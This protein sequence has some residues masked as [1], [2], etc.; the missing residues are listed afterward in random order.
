[1]K[2]SLKWLKE[3]IDTKLSDS[4]LIEKLTDLG[5]ECSLSKIGPSFNKIVVGKVEKV[6]K[7][8]N[9]DHL[10]LCQVNIGEKSFLQI[11]C[12]APNVK[13]DIHVPVA[14]IGASLDNGNF[15]IKKTEIRGEDSEGMICSEKELDLGSNNEG[16]MILDK[17]SKI[18]T[19][20]KDFLNLK[21]DTLIDFDLTPNRGDCLS[22]LGIAREVAILESKCHKTLMKKVIADN[23][24]S[25]A[26]ND[27]FVIDNI[28]IN[29]EDI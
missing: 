14:I 6:E 12:G 28:T 27:D 9:S 15:K 3:L 2:V 25:I 18:G 17:K 22:F 19:S 5:L 16:I 8:S 20:F 26:E 7:H 11:V 24:F 10:S 21:E 29:I 1:M 23:T 4:K 13:K